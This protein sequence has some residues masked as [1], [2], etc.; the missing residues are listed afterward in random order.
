MA[1]I[2][3]PSPDISRAV[4]DLQ[5]EQ[6][7][8][9]YVPSGLVGSP[10]DTSVI[11]A[12]GGGR[13]V[14]IRLGKYGYV[15][16]HPWYSGTSNV[17]LT[18]AANTSGNPRIDLI[19]LRLTRSTWNVTAAVVQG[20]PAGSPTVPALTQNLT[21]T[22]VFEIPIAQVAV[23]NGA[24]VINLVDVTAKDFYLSRPNLI[25][26][27]AN[28]PLSGVYIGQGY[29]CSDTG[30]DHFW[31][32]PA[33]DSFVPT[34]AVDAANGTTTSTS[35]TATLAGVATPLS[36]AFVARRSVHT[37]VVGTTILQTTTGPWTAWMAPVVTGAGFST[38]GPLDNDAATAQPD[39]INMGSY[40]ERT[41]IVAG[42]TPGVTYTITPQ[43]KAQSG[44]GTAN[45]RDR[46]IV[47]F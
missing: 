34:R 38:Y 24:S 45:F 42:L 44:A 9:G 40:S 17:N 43:F 8:V 13:N 10:G 23:A 21:T 14:I 39:D 15:R 3:W 28:R 25:G 2:S 31:L 20:T 32:G 18:I 6:M 4:T 22:G 11:Y 36:L 1:E 19:V 33:W 37:M 35:Y 47:V 12:D 26:L 29:R 30:Q 5:Y 27:A 16:G 7:M 41:S 46:T